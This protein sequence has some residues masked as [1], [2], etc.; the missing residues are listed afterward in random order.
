MRQF[1][2]ASLFSSALSTQYSV[3]STQYSALSTQHSVLFSCRRRNR[4]L[5]SLGAAQQLN[6]VF[7]SRFH[8]SQRIGVIVNVV[9]FAAGEFHNPVARFYSSLGCR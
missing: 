4:Q 1:H 8:F 7:L 6:F 3:L 5:H 2:A 9:H